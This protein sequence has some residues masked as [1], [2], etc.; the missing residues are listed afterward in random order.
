MDKTLKKDQYDAIMKNCNKQQ[1]L[2]AEAVK[3]K[4][5]ND[6]GYPTHICFKR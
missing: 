5:E 1:A 4:N 3:E 2:L 6:V